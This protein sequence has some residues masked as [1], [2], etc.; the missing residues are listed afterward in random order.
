MLIASVT[1]VIRFGDAPSPGRSG[2]NPPL[3]T[4]SV[5]RF[6]DRKPGHIPSQAPIRNKPSACLTKVKLAA[7]S[8]LGGVPKRRE[9]GGR[10]AGGEGGVAGGGWAGGGCLGEVAGGRGGVGWGLWGEV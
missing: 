9:V 4:I 7:L 8:G 2:T 3:C 10:G 6:G 1:K 5:V